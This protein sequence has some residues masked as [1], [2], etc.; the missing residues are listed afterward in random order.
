MTAKTKKTSVIK[1][2]K[3]EVDDFQGLAEGRRPRA[4]SAEPEDIGIDNTY[5]QPYEPDREVSTSIYPGATITFER[6]D[7]Q[8]RMSSTYPSTNHIFPAITRK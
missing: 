8:E 5:F 1:K 3:Q 2:L 7:R 6:D 4:W